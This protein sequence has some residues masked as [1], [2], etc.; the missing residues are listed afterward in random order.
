ME[1]FKIKNM[2]FYGDGIAK[3]QSLA[4]EVIVK[5]QSMFDKETVS[6]GSCLS[7]PQYTPAPHPTSILPSGLV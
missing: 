6:I 1:K 2:Q 5:F 7:R 4:N 3:Q